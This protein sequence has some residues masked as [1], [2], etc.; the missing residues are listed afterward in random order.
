M[1]TIRR[2]YIYKI[3]ID[4]LVHLNKVIKDNNDSKSYF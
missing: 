4:E 1:L 2:F 3:I